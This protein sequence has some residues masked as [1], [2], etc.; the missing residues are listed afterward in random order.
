MSTDPKRLDRSRT[1]RWL[2][3]ICGGL[4]HY[5]NLDPTLIR[6]LF[7]LF[8]LA[9]GGGFLAYVILWLI[10]P[11]EPEKVEQSVGDSPQEE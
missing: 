1:N 3:G 6:V 9:F 4:G 8:A 7:V 10:I 2:A 11:L 5:F